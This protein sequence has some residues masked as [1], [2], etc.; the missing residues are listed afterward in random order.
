M[1]IIIL[2]TI[3]FNFSYGYKCIAYVPDWKEFPNEISLKGITH[4]NY[5]FGIPDENGNITYNINALDKLSNICKNNNINLVFSIG[6]WSGSR[7]FSNIAKNKNL[8]KNFTGNLKTII[9]N[10]KYNISGIDLDWEYPGKSNACVGNIFSNDDHK[11]LGGLL[12]AIKKEFNN[13]EISMAVPIEPWTNNKDDLKDLNYINI[14]AYDVNGAYWSDKTGSNSPY[15]NMVEGIKNWKKL[16]LNDSQIIIGLPFY[17]RTFYTNE[18]PIKPNV[19]NLK[20]IG[21]VKGGPSDTPWE[22]KCF[23]KTLLDNKI[24][25]NNYKMYNTIW[26]YSELIDD[27]KKNKYWIQSW[28]NEANTP[29]AYYKNK[30]HNYWY[31]VSYDNE[32]SIKHKVK[33]VKK[34]NL[35]G[36]MAWEITQDNGDLLKVVTIYI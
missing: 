23:N 1:L 16:G 4:L 33:Y 17:G 2:F 28:D 32:K 35:G 36:I 12:K 27:F 26:S 18:K 22:D 19:N 3:I 29:Y 13:I 25:E 20:Q 6:G 34:Q 21:D 14:M 9:N 5:A 15:K 11:N 24:K 31:Y 8:L 10:K 30:T 7:Y